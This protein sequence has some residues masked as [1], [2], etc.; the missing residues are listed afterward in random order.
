VGVR[1]S[2]TLGDAS[3]C[4]L[5]LVFLLFLS[6]V[7]ATTAQGE[8]M[9]ATA[10]P[11]FKVSPRV[12][13][14]PKLELSSAG[15]GASETESFTIVNSGA[16]PI[17]LMV[18]SPGAPFA[19]T[20]G[21]GSMALDAGQRASV[22]VAFHPT[23]AGKFHGTI[24]I[25]G[26][27]SSSGAKSRQVKLKGKAKR[28]KSTPTPTPTVTSTATPAPTVRP[29]PTA[30]PTSSPT[31]TATTSP[32]TT[33][34]ATT[35]PTPTVTATPTRT[36][37]ATAS[38]T[39]TPTPTATST[40]TAAG[41]PSQLFAPYVDMTL[42]PTFSLTDNLSSV[43]RYYTLAFIVD[44]T[45]RGCTASWGTY[46]VLSDNFPDADIANV[47]AAGGDVIVSFGGQ[48][49][50]ELAQSCTSVNALEAQYDAVVQRYNL[51]RIDF[52]VEGAA[53]ADS[54]S[55]SRRNQALALLQA[56]HPGLQI[57]YTLP[58]MPFGLTQD[59]INLISDAIKK[60]VNV[61]AV[62][63]MAM[64]YGDGTT[65][66]GQAAIDAATATAGQLAALYPNKT[67]AQIN[68]MI[69]V[70]P[71]IGYNDV[72]GEI[73]QLS[74]AQTLLGYARTNGLNLLAFWSAARDVQ[75]PSS[76]SQPQNTC[77]GLAQ[78]PFQFS[79]IF[80][81]INT[82][83]TF[84][85][86]FVVVEENH[87]YSAVVGN[88]TEM[89][90]LNQLIS[91]SAVATQY[92]AN[93]HPSLPN[94]LWMTSGGSDG[95]TGDPCES[96]TGPLDVDNL[97]RELNNAHLSWKAYQ[98]GLP[99]A[100]YMGCGS[101]EYAQRHNP[102]AYY[103]DVANS[104][105]EQQKIVPFSQFATDLANG[106]L[107]KFSFITPNLQDDAHDGTLAQADSWLQTNLAPLLASPM[108]QPGGNGLLIITFDEGSDSTNGGGR[109]LWVAISPRAKPGYQSTT[110]YQH[111]STLRL[112]LEA[113]GVST[114][115][116]ATAQA[117]DMS[118][119]FQ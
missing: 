115:P 44:Q 81:Q 67:A 55:I 57:S 75:C 18:G 20:V 92:Y 23:A 28:A 56:A 112:V 11:S 46:Y 114:F 74:D 63:I 13:H 100:G 110:L 82:L 95:V 45:G 25:T 89:P 5:R 32:S 97:V 24:L 86:V 103:R 37:T 70:T 65:Q 22:T 15:S 54:A 71:M 101:G 29:T 118:E 27:G 49:N 90:Y 4:P 7:L 105:S 64:D 66:M 60:G 48:A 38:A 102:F 78:T 73:F 34:T 69:G 93:A 21:A 83:P 80:K 31:P 99:S 117:P 77:S 113:L 2:S 107:P 19:I 41:F 14:F 3:V 106:T 98:E 85:N 109:V 87:G 26:Q 72:A 76:Q 12:L 39:R 17:S 40:S 79:G 6:A 119:F 42:W 53:V 111:Q 116:G 52:D 104:V 88:T 62:N 108:F 30:T 35:T 8:A 33:P 36:A 59:G 10:R 91:R 96:T 43:G 9:A 50:T 61:A 84:S 1:G 16:M 94:Y 51:K 68:A 58:V 47:R